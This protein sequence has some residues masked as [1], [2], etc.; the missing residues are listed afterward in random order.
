MPKHPET[1][2]LLA[3]LNIATSNYTKARSVLR[4]LAKSDPTMRSL[5]IMAAIER[6]E[7]ADDQTVRQLLTQAISAQRDPQWICENCGETYQSWEPVCLNCDAIDSVSWKRPP[8]SESVSAEMLPLIVGQ[9]AKVD[10]DVTSGG[11]DNETEARS[12]TKILDK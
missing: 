3:E 10:Q 2:M 4:G 6:G 11:F 1:K 5:T 8:P 12:E 7:G 9:M